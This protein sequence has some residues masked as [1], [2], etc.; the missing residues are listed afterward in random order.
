MRRV[1][2]VSLIA[3]TASVSF[4]MSAEAAVVYRASEGWSTQSPNEEDT[5]E[6]TASAQLHKAE[7]LEKDG[8][9][10]R[11]LAAY[12]GLVRKF[13]TSGVAAKAQFKAGQTAEQLG[14]YDRAFNAYGDYLSKYPK[15]E[16]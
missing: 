6:S 16:D 14:D 10:K 12:R 4:F 3:V 5:V 1:F 7:A 2:A 9:F 11:A 8:D 15:G 13:P